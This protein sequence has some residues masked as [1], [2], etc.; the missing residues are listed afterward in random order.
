MLRSNNGLGYDVVTHLSKSLEGKHHLYFDRFFTSSLYM[1]HLLEK[2]ISA[3]GTVMTNP[4]NLPANI[5]KIKLKKTDE[6]KA[7]Q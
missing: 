3:S 1:K 2:G 7:F 5:N 6:S 4:K